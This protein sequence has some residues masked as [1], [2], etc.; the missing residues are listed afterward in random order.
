MSDITNLAAEPRALG[1]KGAAKA[2]R[3]TG[4][5]PAVI[6]GGKQDPEPITLEY[7]PIL[8]GY[9][10]GTFLSTVYTVEL[11]G[12]KQRVIPKD[13]QLD[14]VRDFIVHVDFMRIAKGASVTVGV[15]VTFLN[16]ETSPGLRRGGALN[17]VRFEIEVSCPADAIPDA[18]EVDLGS[19]EIGDSIHISE[20]TLPNG[21]TPTITDRD[22]TI[23]TIAGAGGGSDSEEGDAEDESGTSDSDSAASE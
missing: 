8:K 1:G 22:F 6:Y 17:V 5:V 15:P 18:I 2:I 3:R 13:I 11:Q 20:V 16:E 10:S 14:P 4:R 19:A 23:V 7:L 12:K 9:E 21:V